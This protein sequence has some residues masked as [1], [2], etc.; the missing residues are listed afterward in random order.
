MGAAPSANSRAVAEPASEK[1]GC[2]LLSCGERTRVMVSPTR[3]SP[4][5]MPPVAS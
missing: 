4:L 1:M 3:R 2:V 5:R